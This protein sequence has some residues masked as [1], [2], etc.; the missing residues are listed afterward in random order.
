MTGRAD[1]GDGPTD[2]TLDSDPFRVKRMT[3]LKADP[4]VVA[5]RRVTL[6][7]LYP[8]P[9]KDALLA[10]PRRVV[11][12]R[13]LLQAGHRTV[14][15]RPTKLGVFRARVPRGAAVSLRSLRDRCGNRSG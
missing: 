12:G 15:A 2:Y 5:G 11:S 8:D 4:P 13:A 6:R 3:T 1:R 10:L 7:A 14:R 9:G